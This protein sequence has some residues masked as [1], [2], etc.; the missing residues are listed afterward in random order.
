[1]CNFLH[2]WWFAVHCQRRPSVLMCQFDEG[3]LAY[4]MLFPCK[5]PLLH[6]ERW[7]CRVWLCTSMYAR[8]LRRCFTAADSQ[9]KGND[10]L[11]TV[12]G[13][14]STS[15]CGANLSGE[16]VQSNEHAAG[17]IVCVLVS[18]DSNV[19]NHL[20]NHVF[21]PSTVKY[22]RKMIQVNDGKWEQVLGSKYQQ[23]YET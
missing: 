20:F 18:R 11:A 5:V 12:V 21:H 14:G 3:S 17:P 10:V 16:G 4:S 22:R 6:L 8:T 13:G 15:S 1:M 2:P 19:C 23:H 7:Q 9:W